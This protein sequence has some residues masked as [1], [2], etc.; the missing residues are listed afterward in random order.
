[1][2]GDR[3]TSDQRRIGLAINYI[4]PGMRQVVAREDFAVL[5]RGEDRYGHFRHVPAPAGDLSQE[6]L[7]WHRRILSAQNEVL[8]EG[9]EQAQA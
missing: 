1:M 9:A 3:T 4:A 2:I 7:A 8:Y 6:A 5:V